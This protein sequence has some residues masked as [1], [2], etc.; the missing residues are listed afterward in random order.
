M[1]AIV[2]H[3]RFVSPTQLE[4]T[5][6]VSTIPGEVEIVVRPLP[7]AEK[8]SAAELLEFIQS[9]PPG[10]RSKEDIDA[11]IREERDSWE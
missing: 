4:L 2:A 7:P 9:L 8:S 6:P 3:G 5:D 11:Q 10:N 1:N